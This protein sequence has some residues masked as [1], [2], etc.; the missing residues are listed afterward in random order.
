MISADNDDDDGD[1]SDD[2]DNDN[3]YGKT[4]D[5]YTNF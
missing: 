4:I 3:L 5:I 1:D 2:E